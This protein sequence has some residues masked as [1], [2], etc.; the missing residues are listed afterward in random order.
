M[1]KNILRTEP[2]ALRLRVVVVLTAV[3]MDLGVPW[4]VPLLE[5]GQGSISPCDVVFSALTGDVS[6]NPFSE[7]LY[8]ALSIGAVKSV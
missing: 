2:N 4:L 6:V 5:L 1:Q 8:E 3:S 7:G